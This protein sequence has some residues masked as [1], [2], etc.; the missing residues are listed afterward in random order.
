MM[1][2]ITGAQT[3]IAREFVKLMPISDHDIV[4]IGRN[5][6]MI[7]TA[8]A[9]LFCQ[10]YLAGRDAAGID[11][12][13]AI[14]TWADNFGTVAANCDFILKHNPRA[15]ICII[16]SYSGIKGSFDAT[17]A[18]AKAGIHLYIET[19]RLQHPGQQIVGIAPH[20]IMDSGMTRRRGDLDALNERGAH[21]GRD[22]IT[23]ADV[24]RLAHFLL[25][26]DTG[27]ICNVVVPMTGGV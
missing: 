7:T 19:K 15:R 11:R 24:A 2:A 27:N 16:G 23:P 17:Y 4:E 1:V 5:R 3:T 12:E 25:C 21:R 8:D 14:R 10:G 18:A 6:G 22:W 13:E 26:I 9:Y 20:I